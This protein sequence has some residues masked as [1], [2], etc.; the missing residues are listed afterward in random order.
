MA[1]NI[2]LIFFRKPKSK[3]ILV[4]FLMN[5]NETSIPVKTDCYPYYHW[6]DVK[7]F[8]RDKIKASGLDL[9]QYTTK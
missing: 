3:D 4:K 7:K 5:E 2:Q 8:Y 1:A 9:D 6:N